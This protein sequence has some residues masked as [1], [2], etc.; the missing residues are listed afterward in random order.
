MKTK[1]WPFLDVYPNKTK[2]VQRIK[3]FKAVATGQLM[4]IAAE[5]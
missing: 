3:K 2:H 5:G 4:I 1:F